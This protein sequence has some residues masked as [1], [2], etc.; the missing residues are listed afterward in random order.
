MRLKRLVGLLV[1]SFITGVL[2]FFRGTASE[3]ASL[4]GRDVLMSEPETQ[5]QDPVPEESGEGT[6]APLPDDMVIA[7]GVFIGDFDLGGKTRGEAAQII[8]DHIS[9]LQSKQIILKVTDKE[10][11]VAASELGFSWGNPE[12]VDKAA[13]LGTQGDL[14]ARY[15]TLKDLKTEKKVLALDITYDEGLAAGFVDRVAAK[16]D[17]PAKDATLTRK[18]GKFVVTPETLGLVTNKEETT[19]KLLDAIRENDA[20]PQLTIEGTV[21]ESRPVRTADAL[22]RVKHVL[23]SYTTTYSQANVGRS[24]N[25]TTAVSKINGSILMPGEIFSGYEKMAPFTTSNGY[26]AAGAYQNGVVIESV[27]GGACQIA[28]TIYNAVLL[29]ELEVTQRQNHSMVVHYVPYS[30]DAAIAGTY[31]DI[32]FKNNYDSPVYI[33]CSASGGNLTFVIYGNDTRPSNRTIKYQSVTLS[34]TW[35]QNPIVTQSGDYP[36]GFQKQEQGP[37]PGVSS[38]LWKYVYVDGVQKE[39]ILVNSDRYNS[40]PAR[41][42]V[43][44]GP[45]AAA[46]EGEAADPNAAEAGTGEA[47]QPGETQAPQTET[48][49]P[50][51]SQAEPV[52]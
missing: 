18:G 38:Q 23:G 19:A 41:I 46:A 44:T 47:Q 22:S 49:A 50:S 7:E 30:F 34:E 40:S 3:A 10:E 48:A 29:A 43:G 26:A 14:I 16:Y 12:V 1:F 11:T 32:K 2:V 20:Q 45:A 9:R 33:E 52:E 42:I 28:T 24:K 25:L 36:A 39:K 17:I 15:K 6:L 13:A 21:V 37:Y 27:G 31:K 51:E 5:A 8:N 4:P 35:P